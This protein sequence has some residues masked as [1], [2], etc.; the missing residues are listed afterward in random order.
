M[1]WNCK[2]MIY[3]QCTILNFN[4]KYCSKVHV[5][6]QHCKISI[7]ESNLYELMPNEAHVIVTHIVVSLSLYRLMWMVLQTLSVCLCVCPAFGLYF[8]TYGSDFNETLWKFQKSGLMDCNIISWKLFYTFPT[9]YF[10]A[11]GNIS[12]LTSLKYH[13]KHDQNT[14]KRCIFPS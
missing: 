7:N 4:S 2:F 13:R 3:F 1:V 5:C 10:L 11:W 9:D 8:G 14:T 6:I 12:A